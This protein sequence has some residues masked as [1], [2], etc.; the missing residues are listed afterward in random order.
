MSYKSK[1]SY[2]NWVNSPRGRANHLLGTYNLNDKKYNRGKGDLTV[3]WI[4]DNIFTQPCAHCGKIGWDIIGCNRLDNSLP[5]TKDNVEP[6]CVECNRKLGNL[7]LSIKRSLPVNQIDPKTG[8]IIK[9]WNSAKEA[10]RNGY[11]YGNIR[12]CCN[13]GFY[14]KGKWV[15]VTQH[16]GYFW[17][18]KKNGE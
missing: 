4:V 3:D 11:S 12:N 10:G 8:E 2:Y 9:T 6:C 16:K 1:K 14:K 15:N 7:E 5:H 17:E 18:Y 13:G